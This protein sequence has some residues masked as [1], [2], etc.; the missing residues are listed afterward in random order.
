VWA[1]QAAWL[2]FG[3][4]SKLIYAKV[5]LAELSIGLGTI[6]TFFTETLVL[7]TGVMYPFH[8]LPA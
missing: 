2:A 8:P 5:V 3:V 1:D 7:Y 4:Q 6:K